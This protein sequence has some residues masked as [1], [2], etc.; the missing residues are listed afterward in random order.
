MF[1][2]EPAINISLYKAYSFNYIHRQFP[3]AEHWAHQCH[4]HFKGLIHQTAN[5]L[6]KTAIKPPRSAAMNRVP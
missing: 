4:G 3:R 1:S 5:C 6:P 2:N